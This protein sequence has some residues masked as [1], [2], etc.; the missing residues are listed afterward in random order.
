MTDYRDKIKTPS[1]VKNENMI[2]NFEWDLWGAEVDLLSIG[3]NGKKS[4]ITR[5]DISSFLSGV[6]DSVV[7]ANIQNADAREQA[8][9]AQ[10]KEGKSSDYITR[11]LKGWDAVETVIA[12]TGETN[13]NI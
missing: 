13:E 12:I 8:I 2:V 4:I 6:L 3:I 9:L 11:Y 7:L 1:R 10:Q 5:D